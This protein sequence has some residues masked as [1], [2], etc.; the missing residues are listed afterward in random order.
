M[1]L[2]AAMNDSHGER[3]RRISRVAGASAQ[4]AEGA[5]AA[6]RRGANRRLVTVY[7]PTGDLPVGRI[8]KGINAPVA[9]AIDLEENVY[10]ANAYDDDVTVNSPGA[11]VVI[12]RASVIK[13]C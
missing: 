8:K 1:L 6:H 9:L 4:S 13:S 2:D 7:G 3:H 5:E 12:V 11:E 10:L